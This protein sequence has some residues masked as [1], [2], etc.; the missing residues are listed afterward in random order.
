MASSWSSEELSN[1]KRKY[2]CEVIVDN[3]TIEQVMTKA[4][5]RDAYI[6]KY[7]VDG[8]VRYD[9]TRSAKRVRI[10]DMYYDKFGAGAMLDIDFGYGQVLPKLWG[11]VQV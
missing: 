9:L 4:A 8:E 11:V 2:S 3:G 10:F 6:I 5:P 1:S 7:Q